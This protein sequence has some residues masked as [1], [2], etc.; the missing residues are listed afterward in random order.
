[1]AL[2]LLSEWPPQE[3]VALPSAAAPSGPVQ[4]WLAVL[5]AILAGTQGRK[6]RARS[7]GAE[8]VGPCVGGPDVLHG[9]AL[10]LMCCM[11]GPSCSFATIPPLLKVQQGSSGSAPSSGFV[12]HASLQALLGAWA[13]LWL[14]QGWPS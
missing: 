8:M 6:G 3:L 14:L 13:L 5:G 9:G 11:V 12:T 4:P 2:P 1:M 7:A 10:M